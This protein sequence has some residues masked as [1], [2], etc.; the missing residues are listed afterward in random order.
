MLDIFADYI[1]KWFGISE[2]LKKPFYFLILLQNNIGI[3]LH[4]Q[5]SCKAILRMN[6]SKRESKNAIEHIRM[7]FLDH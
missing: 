2:N 6:K 5:R 7:G 3:E 1:L 4:N